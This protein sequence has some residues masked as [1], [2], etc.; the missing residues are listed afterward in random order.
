MTLCLA[1]PPP[2]Y[3]K[4][5]E[6]DK[7]PPKYEFGYDVRDG[8]GGR[9]GHLETRDGVYA[10]GVYYVNLPDGSGQSVR[11]FADDWGYHPLVSYSSSSKTGTTKTQ[12]ALGEKAVA[13]LAKSKETNPSVSV[14]RPTVTTLISSALKL[15]EDSGGGDADSGDILKIRP[16][17]VKL[18]ANRL[19][20]TGRKPTISYQQASRP[21]E[22]QVDVSAVNNLV[23]S[24]SDSGNGKYKVVTPLYTTP[25]KISGSDSHS[26][27]YGPEEAS[28]YEPGQVYQHIGTKG[29]G[30]SSYQFIEIGGDSSGGEHFRS[31]SP[32]VSQLITKP[33]NTQS[34]KLFGHKGAEN[35]KVTSYLGDVNSP[36]KFGDRIPN[37]NSDFT[38]T[39]ASVE[40]DQNEIHKGK[41]EVLEVTPLP[42]SQ[43]HPPLRPIIVAD[44][45]PKETIGTVRPITILP[46]T[47]PVSIYVTHSPETPSSTSTSSSGSALTS[48]TNTLKHATGSTYSTP[49][50]LLSQ[51]QAGS[52]SYS[53]ES[54]SN[55]QSF[56]SITNNGLSGHILP[57]VYSTQKPIIMS[58]TK[59]TASTSFTFG[60]DGSS[61]ST[62]SGG[63]TADAGTQAYKTPAPLAV[64]YVQSISGA[65]EVNSQPAA[66]GH[67]TSK[68]QQTP[69]PIFVYYST[70]SPYSHTSSSAVSGTSNDHGVSDV[71]ST[72]A[73]LSLSESQE[74]S[75]SEADENSKQQSTITINSGNAE[76]TIENQ[77][78]I[79][80]TVYISHTPMSSS[81]SVSISN[82]VN[83]ESK[84]SVTATKNAESGQLI[85]NNIHST[86]PRPSAEYY[87]NSEGSSS[88]KYIVS[89]ATILLNSNTQPVAAALTSSAEVLS[90]I[91]AAV[92]LGTASHQNPTAVSAVS[93][94]SALTPPEVKEA[95]EIPQ[96]KTVVEVQKAISLD[97]N[98]LTVK[99][100]TEQKPDLEATTP[101]API[102]YSQQTVGKGKEVD[103]SSSQQHIYNGGLLEYTYGQPLTGL[104]VYPQLRYNFPHISG[105]TDQVLLGYN[106]QLYETQKLVHLGYN[107]QEQLHGGV[108]HEA[109]YEHSFERHREYTQ[110]QL[111]GQLQAIA[112]YQEGTEAEKPREKYQYN[113]NSAS[114]LKIYQEQ[115]DADKQP[116]ETSYIQKFYGKEHLVLQEKLPEKTQTEEEHSKKSVQME[117]DVQKPQVP[118]QIIHELKYEQPFRV[119]EP[120]EH[121]SPI[122]NNQ[123]SYQL[124]GQQIGYD[125]PAGVQQEI[126]YLGPTKLKQ[127]VEQTVNT[128]I[129][130]S[131]YGHQTISTPDNIVQITQG[132]EQGP[133]S[134]GQPQYNRNPSEVSKQLQSEYSHQLLEEERQEQVRLSSQIGKALNQINAE[135][136]EASVRTQF[137]V[138]IL[139]EGKIVSLPVAANLPT[140]SPTTFVPLNQ[141]PQSIEQIKLV[142][143]EKRVPVHDTKV[144][145]KPIPVPHAVPIEITKLVAVDRPVPYPQPYAV[146]H[147]VPV[148]YAVPHPVGVPVP[149]LVPYPHVV[150]VPYK[151]VH[152]VYIHTGKPHR[153]EFRDH[154][155]NI[156]TNTPLPVILK[157]LQYNGGRYGVPVSI[158]PQSVFLTPPPLR[159]GGK[160]RGLQQ[161]KHFDHF[162]TLCI[163]YGFKPPLVPSL[164]IDEV[165]LSAYGPP[166]KD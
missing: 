9:Q 65:Q 101:A 47:T 24:K 164:Q 156:P 89:P 29:I 149:H 45:Y 14:T 117:T 109:P 108:Q 112:G 94:E 133:R 137:P 62:G 87:S 105:S 83:S 121:R 110:K 155:Q 48:P 166:R 111:D 59:E 107:R 76:K 46:T 63:H 11:Y 39:T 26:S 78:S 43:R 98:D 30:S 15:S 154:T 113:Q 163:E 67:A 19:V 165:P 71:Y 66:S 118:V 60:S 18:S 49:T 136:N 3:V 52:L 150:T 103:H 56:G 81:F 50:N 159:P 114:N 147:P 162:R 8:K 119:N 27:S 17:N 97:L 16:S 124:L 141:P 23:E 131:G 134:K 38:Q 143:V 12:F 33:T 148:P 64:S 84:S 77:Q 92:S 91:H 158:K 4:K 36:L 116:A 85:H 93:S 31:P 82:S 104:Q 79:P 151:E 90:P 61:L 51:S 37:V 5:P 128:A 1:T 106:P 75:P 96:S 57:P 6:K 25:N 160:A 102:L 115:E 53:S 88:G 7:D 80:A 142:E 32:A 22:E 40:Q 157:A 130:Q 140:L 28:A 126:E 135:Y 152:P 95:N 138:H 145:E 125:A 120:V 127:Q 58:N 69:S 68:A 2:G 99:L 13:A 73:P 123:V 129:V 54:E 100:N 144:I 74:F 139:N 70:L 161:S 41:Q 42:I 21:S 35:V 132:S 44:I 86:T 153:N 55:S 146:P 122:E 72:P 10:L 34:Q 20:G